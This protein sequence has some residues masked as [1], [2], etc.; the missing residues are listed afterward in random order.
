MHIGIAKS[1]V[2]SVAD[3]AMEHWWLSNPALMGVELI[4]VLLLFWV[5]VKL[6]VKSLHL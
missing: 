2:I 4:I 1:G 5:Y 3:L 6:T